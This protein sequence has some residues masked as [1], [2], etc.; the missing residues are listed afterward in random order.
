MNKRLTLPA[1]AAFALLS[2]CGNEEGRGGLTADEERQLDN[3]AAMLD[4]NMIDV[5][6]DSLVANEAELDAME[7]ES[8]MDEANGANA[9]E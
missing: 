8:G 2:A 9:Q 6:P 7:A 5:S 1:L 4:D 3:A